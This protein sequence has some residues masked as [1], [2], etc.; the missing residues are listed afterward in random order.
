MEDLFPG[1]KARGAQDSRRHRHNSLEWAAGQP[2]PAKSSSHDGSLTIEV[3]AVA[4]HLM[5]EVADCVRQVGSA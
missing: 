2:V 4:A 1:L 5:W 3:I